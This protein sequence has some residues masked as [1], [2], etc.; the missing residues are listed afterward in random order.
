MKSTGLWDPSKKR[1]VIGW[2]MDECAA[3]E[4]GCIRKRKTNNSIKTVTRN[5]LRHLHLIDF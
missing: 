3:G 2:V 4:T 5:L 1:Y